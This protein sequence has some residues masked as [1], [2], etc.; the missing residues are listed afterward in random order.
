MNVP[1]LLFKWLLQESYTPNQ[2]LPQIL[3]LIP[4]YAEINHLLYKIVFS[5]IVFHE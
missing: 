5:I 3:S 1:Q 4:L 2:Y